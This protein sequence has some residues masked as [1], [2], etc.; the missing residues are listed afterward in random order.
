MPN[1]LSFLDQQPSTFFPHKNILSLMS[2]E[3]II[4]IPAAPYLVR[5]LLPMRGVAAI[6]GESGSGK[7]FLAMDLAIAVASG[8]TR[9]FG[10]PIRQSP[11]VYVA[12]EGQGGL[13]QRLLAWEAHS[14]QPLPSDISFKLSEFTLMSP[15]DVEYLARETLEMYGFGC[16]VVVDTLNQSAPGADENSSADMGL[17][18]SGAQTLSEM[19]QGLVILIHHSGKDRSRG[20][21]GHSSLNAA[22]DA[23]IEVTA[24]AQGRSW[25]VRKAK[26]DEGGICHDFELV[27]H[28]VDVDSE[29]YSISSCAVRQAINA[30]AKKTKPVSGRHQRAAMEKMQ[31]LLNGNQAHVSWKAAV[32]EVALVLDCPE[33]RRMTVAKETL[34][35]LQLNGHLSIHEG[36]LSLT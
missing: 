7:S 22:M 20:M 29:G 8:H 36:E 32:A 34:E 15:D 11:V 17:I 9:W 2:A 26:D 30:P 14:N 25:N 23:V 18:L 28:T 6:Y 4:A 3:Q 33:G 16:V 19:T 13:R 5:G 27:R 24:S 21:R 31:V 12:L 1:E 10:Y 35:R